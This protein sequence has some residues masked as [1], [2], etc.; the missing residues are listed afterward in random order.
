M[1]FEMEDLEP[2]KQEKKP[3]DIS[4]WS[5]DELGEYI[6]ALKAEI[7]RAEAVIAARKDQTST[8][9]AVFKK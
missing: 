5:A 3:T 7:K 1:A 8:A 4:E 6:E 9:A 2:Q